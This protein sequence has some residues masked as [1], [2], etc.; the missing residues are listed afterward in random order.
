MGVGSHNVEALNRSRVDCQV[1]GIA[2]TLICVLKNVS[3]R[4]IRGLTILV[5]GKLEVL[6]ERTVV[7]TV[8]S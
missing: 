1:G 8:E 7:S 4:H 2:V 3:G 6:V 5:V